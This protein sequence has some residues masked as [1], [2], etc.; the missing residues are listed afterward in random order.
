MGALGAHF[1]F[2]PQNQTDHQHQPPSHHHLT[3]STH[4][5]PNPHHY[6]EYNHYCRSTGH[7][8]PVLASRALPSSQ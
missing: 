7:N 4:N 2:N 3:T 8:R 1:C 5:N 6:H